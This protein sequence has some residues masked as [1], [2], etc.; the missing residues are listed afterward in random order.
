MSPAWVRYGN[1][2]GWLHRGS[3]PAKEL[4]GATFWAQ[5]ARVACAA[6]GGNLDM[7]QCYD[8]G[9]F[10]AGPLG[11]TIA[12]GALARFL[13]DIPMNL[14]VTHLGALAERYGLGFCAS[15]REFKIGLRTAT[16]E[17]LRR[18]FV[19]GS[20]FYAWHPTDP[21]ALQAREWVE[22]F[23]ALLA[24]P[25]ARRGIGIASAQVVAGYLDSAASS[26]FN[27]T[28]V[29][30]IMPASMRRP[31][32]CYLAFAI[33]NP[34]GAARLLAMAGADADKML[35]TA[36]RP[37]PWPDTFAQRVGRTRAALDAEAWG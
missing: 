24:D 21:A 1:D 33:N 4:I 19:G 32:A 6:E 13:A 37:G 5:A 36:S 30:E 34:R 12:S 10:T 8:A 14:L 18:V 9:V 17:D 11:A 2:H 15:D 23:A 26:I 28:R 16:I 29:G 3:I 22:A 35:D 20:T 7:V 25:A 31:A 27:A